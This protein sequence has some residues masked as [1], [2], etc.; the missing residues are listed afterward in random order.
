MR[1]MLAWSALTLAGCGNAEPPL[2]GRMS[3]D[4]EAGARVIARIECGVCHTI[5][6]IVGAR[7]IV[8]PSLAGFA[9]RSYIAG[10]VPNRPSTLARWVRD[11]PSMSPDTLMPEL[12]VSERESHDIAAYLYTLE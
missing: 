5:P 9:R 12:P 3:G 11:A 2:A 6:G 7:G 8:G 1:R 10:V 4:P